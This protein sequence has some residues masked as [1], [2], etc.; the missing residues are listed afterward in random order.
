MDLEKMG[1]KTGI[2]VESAYEM[3]YRR[4]LVNAA[5]NLRVP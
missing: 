4:T 1:I 3:D 5:L 2:W